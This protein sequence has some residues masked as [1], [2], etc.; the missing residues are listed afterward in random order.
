MAA[1]LRGCALA[2]ALPLL[3][4]GSGCDTRPEVGDVAA[5][6]VAIIGWDAANW[7]VLDPMLER[8]ELPA[9]AALLKR[10][11]RGVLVAE[12]PL[13][14]PVAWTTLATG[15]RPEEHGILNFTM[16][17]LRGG[18]EQVLVTSSHRKRAPLWK[19]VSSLGRSAGIVGWWTTW[20]AEP[21]DGFIVS[22][23]LAFNRWDSWAQRGGPG[24]ADANDWLTWPPE[25]AAE[26]RPQAR[27]PE[28]IALETLTSIVPFNAREQREMMS[29]KGPVLF[30][31]PSVFRFGYST[32]ASNFSF[33]MHMLKQNEL[34][35]LFATLFV[36]GDIAGHSFWHHYEPD[37]FAEFDAAE[38]HLSD[39]IPSAYRQ[40]DRW[41]AALVAQLEPTT[42]I[43]IVSDHGMGPEGVV[44]EPGVNPAGDHLPEGILVVAGPKALRGF[45][46]GEIASVDFAPTV[47]SLLGLPSAEDMPGRAPWKRAS[48][49][50]GPVVSYGDGRTEFDANP[51]EAGAAGKRST[52][53]SEYLERLRALGYI[54]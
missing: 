29:A 10:G 53:E 34:P 17:D 4:L 12:E 38:A 27:P 8:G 5:A 13:L 3:M 41:T 20:P 48:E 54:K 52:A 23:H 45:D 43:V 40:I 32:D 15:F 44:P 9:L 28:G 16:R 46:F 19:I 24:G 11:A 37:R 7:E 47:L 33:G 36:L 2:C 1:T 31:G 49:A 18:D 39:A 14:S 21:V 25:L 42:T 22:D 51:A 26:L 30:H 35:N 6:K 50:P